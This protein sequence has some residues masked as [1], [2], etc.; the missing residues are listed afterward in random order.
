MRLYYTQ[1]VNGKVEDVIKRQY[2]FCLFHITLACNNLFFKYSNRFICI[3]V[4]P[5]EVILF[6][7]PLPCTTY[8]TLSLCHSLD[9]LYNAACAYTDC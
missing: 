3:C 7:F 5:A 4:C 6:V 8:C 9:T 1:T 2:E